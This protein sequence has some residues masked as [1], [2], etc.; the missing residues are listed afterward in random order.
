MGDPPRPALE[1]RA[2][3]RSRSS[4]PLIVTPASGPVAADVR[5]VSRSGVCAYLP[6]A[7]PEMTKVRFAIE[8]PTVHGP[9]RVEGEGAVVRCLRHAEGRFEVAVFFTDLPDAE[10]EVLGSFVRGSDRV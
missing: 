3:P 4:F 7:I 8:L 5:D 10:R 9:R 6:T 1:R 2:D